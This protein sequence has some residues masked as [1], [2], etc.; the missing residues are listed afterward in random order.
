MKVMKYMYLWKEGVWITSLILLATFSLWFFPLSWKSM[1]LRKQEKKTQGKQ[2]KLVNTF[3]KVAYIA[4]RL[5]FVR[6]V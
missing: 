6:P 5:N 1:L 3:I 2:E 4:D